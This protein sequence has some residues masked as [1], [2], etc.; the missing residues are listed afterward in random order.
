MTLDTGKK[1]SGHLHCPSTSPRSVPE[2]TSQPASINTR[3]WALG[4][5]SESQVTKAQHAQASSHT[6][7]FNRQGGD[8]QTAED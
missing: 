1:G 7:E 8:F 5:H 2:D 6:P 4:S 3:A